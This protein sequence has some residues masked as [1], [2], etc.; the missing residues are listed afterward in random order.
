MDKV[1]GMNI[2][3]LREYC[4]F[5]GIKS[6]GKMSSLLERLKMHF[7]KHPHQCI[8]S[9]SEEVDRIEN[10]EQL[11]YTP[12]SSRGQSNKNECDR[13]TKDKPTKVGKSVS[14]RVDSQLQQANDLKL[15]FRDVEESM[16]S[17]SGENHEMVKR[18]LDDFDDNSEILS[19]SDAQKFVYA[20]RLL[21][22]A[23]REFMFSDRTIRS[24]DELRDKLVEEFEQQ[25]CVA[26]VIEQ[27]R[28]RRKK[29]G[30]TCIEFVSAMQKIAAQVNL[31]EMS[32]IHHVIEGIGGNE[33][34]KVVLLGATSLKEFKTKLKV[35]EKYVEKL[36]NERGRFQNNVARDVVKPKP[37]LTER[38]QQ[39][40]CYNCGSKEHRADKCTSSTPKCFK[41]NKFGHKAAACTGISKT[42]EIR[43][44]EIG[45]SSNHKTVFINDVAIDALVDTG[46]AVN[47][48]RA[49]E[50]F[51]L[52]EQNLVPV[53][54][55]LIGLGNAKIKPF[56]SFSANV[57]IDDQVFNTKFM[58]ISEKS[59]SQ[60]MIIGNELIN[61]VAVVE[62]SGGNIKFTKTKPR[63]SQE[64]PEV[65]AGRGVKG[66]V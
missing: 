18:W 64:V 44:C 35:Y 51:K 41:C 16:Q 53:E 60:K 30:E 62:I 65:Y 48:I 4:E 50:F 31:D 23:A 6:T 8:K 29:S 32:I 66:C 5:L 33:R 37:N 40:R 17:F 58:V 9:N 39:F 56:G 15:L 24:Y 46:S 55:E 3:E 57:I 34:D 61:Q 38:D 1:V 43:V 54:T 14:L 63:N 10:E 47:L 52:G 19:W 49:D 7:D 45:M 21:R 42:T 11:D 26:D 36:S 59:T 2:Q 12:T 28:K 22:G 13:K 25:V 20:K 27:L